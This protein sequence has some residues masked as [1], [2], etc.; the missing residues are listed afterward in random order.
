M[1]RLL[2][3]GTLMLLL[4]A[5]VTPVMELFDSWDPPGPNNDTELAVF[6]LIL[7]LCLVLLVCKLVAYLAGRVF[8][9]STHQPRPDRTT[10]VRD[11]Q[12]PHRILVPSLSPPPLRI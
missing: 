5:F 1:R 6:G 10:T 12:A 9:V 2:Q 11:L 4:A 3:F 8:I 7:G